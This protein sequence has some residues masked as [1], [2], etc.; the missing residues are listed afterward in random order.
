M[1]HVIHAIHVIHVIR[2]IRAIY[3]IRV[4]YV[5]YVIYVLYVHVLC[6]R[7]ASICRFALCL[8]PSFDFTHKTG[9]S[10]EGRRLSRR[11]SA[12]LLFGLENGHSATY[13]AGRAV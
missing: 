3:V 12:K 7:I 13:G 6:C 9:H 4:I 5:I 8:V 1:I 10:N 2:E 11:S